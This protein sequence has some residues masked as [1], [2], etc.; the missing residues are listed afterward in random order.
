MTSKFELC[1]NKLLTTFGTNFKQLCIE[2]AVARTHNSTFARGGACSADNFVVIESLVLRI[3]ICGE[4][5]T[6]FGKPEN[7]GQN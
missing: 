1:D 6:T 5:S 2:R 4:K 3:N 7:I